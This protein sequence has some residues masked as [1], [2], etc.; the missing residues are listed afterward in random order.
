MWSELEHH[1]VR[2][3]HGYDFWRSILGLPTQG[4]R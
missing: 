3:I 2:Y 4:I 1:I